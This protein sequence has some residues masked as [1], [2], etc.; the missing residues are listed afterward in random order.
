MEKEISNKILEKLDSMDKRFDSVEEN[1]NAFKKDVD[2]RFNDIDDRFNNVDSRFNDVDSKFKNIDDRFND[3]D[4]RF[5]KLEEV[6]TDIKNS[7]AVMEHEHGQKLDVLLEMYEP[8][9]DEHVSLRMQ[10]AKL[11]TDMDWHGL[12]IDLLNRKAQAFSS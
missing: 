4:D 10:I 8:N 2:S 7:T 6:L 11:K 12:K 5:N 9:Y 3:V 1:L